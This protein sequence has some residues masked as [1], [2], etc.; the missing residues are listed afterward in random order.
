MDNTNAKKAIQDEINKIDLTSINENSFLDIKLKNNLESYKG[1]I[2]AEI[3]TNSNQW[4]NTGAWERFL[5]QLLLISKILEE[6][7]DDNYGTLDKVR[8]IRN[9]FEHKIHGIRVLSSV[10]GS[11]S[12]FNI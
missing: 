11:I 5:G 7:K 6:N 2:S 1:I 12:M 9:K 10:Y 8:K 3:K 4:N